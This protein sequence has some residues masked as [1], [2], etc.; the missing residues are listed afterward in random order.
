MCACL[1]VVALTLLC[2]ACA[3]SLPDLG[4]PGGADSGVD[5]GSDED[6][7]PPPSEV[8]I[9][10][11]IDQGST[12][13]RPDQ[14]G[15]LGTP[16]SSAE[17]PFGGAP[18]ADDCSGTV[19]QGSTIEIEP[20]LRSDASGSLGSGFAGWA[21]RECGAS[22]EPSALCDRPS[23]CRFMARRKTEITAFFEP[24]LLLWLPFDGDLVDGSR[25]AHDGRSDSVSWGTDRAG[26]GARALELVSNSPLVGVP[27]DTLDETRFLAGFVAFTVCAFVS[28]SQ[29]PSSDRQAIFV[30]KVGEIQSFALGIDERG[31]VGGRV[32]RQEGL[33]LSTEIPADPRGPIARR[34]YAHV[35]LLYNGDQAAVSL[36]GVTDPSIYRTVAVPRPMRRGPAPVTIGGCAGC[37]SQVEPLRGLVDEL[38]VWR[39][40]LSAVELEVQAT[41]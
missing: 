21:A 34:S 28:P 40:V 31:F 10:L 38:K 24:G 32:W 30:S 22:C 7:G 4:D 1:R 2:S 6:A 11:R 9:D 23:T 26:R 16:E 3:M 27:D 20:Y 15:F 41:R 39:R 17:G 33:N 8:S 13:L 35:C 5:A 12:N 19:S 25:H 18:C 29:F 36:N 37:G 14:G